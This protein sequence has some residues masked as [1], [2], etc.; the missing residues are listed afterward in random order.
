MTSEEKGVY[1]KEY[2]KKHREKF[3]LARKEYR[4]QNADSIKQYAKQYVIKN[5]KK[6]ALKYRYGISEEDYNEKHRSQNERCAI[7]NRPQSEFNE[8]FSVDH[9][10][11]TN[12]IRGLLCPR[13]NFGI[14]YFMDDG[15]L[16]LKAYGYLKF[17]AEQKK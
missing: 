12:Q 16:L 13:C 15:N 2:Y 1:R 6:N 11:S 4:I 8:R 10:H 17:W 3:L 14:G 5:G 7:C 9:C